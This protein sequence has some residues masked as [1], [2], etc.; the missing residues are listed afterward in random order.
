MSTMVYS[1]FYTSVVA[2]GGGSLCCGSGR[3][4]ECIV[5]RVPGMQR[6][7][8]VCASIQMCVCAVRIVDSASGQ[9][10]EAAFISEM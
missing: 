6:G 5:V 7:S 2:V 3:V 10:A 8:A 1:K 9:A 4:H